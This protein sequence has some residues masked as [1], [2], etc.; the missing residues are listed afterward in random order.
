MTS[1][2]I[3]VVEDDPVARRFLADNLLADGY[4][5]LEAGTRAEAQRML[6]RGAADVAVV[7]LGLPDG[8]GLELLRTVRESRGAA[9]VDPYL[10]LIVLSGRA[11]EVER[12]RGFARG[13]DDYV[14]KPYSVMELTARIEAVLRRR[15]RPRLAPIRIGPLEID[16]AAHQVRLHG[17]PVRLSAKEF[18]L[19]RMLAAEP[20][21]VYTRAE[22]LEEVWGYAE[23]LPTRTLDSHAWRLRNKLG[24]RGDRF[25]VNVWGVGYRLAEDGPE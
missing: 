8:D 14:V 6:A 11:S 16:P 12:L 24:A 7:D 23:M 22:L 19:L 15:N 10:P 25:V 20:T 2:T 1:S 3:L 9:A 4:E 13:A 21:R 17:E 5:I 18:R